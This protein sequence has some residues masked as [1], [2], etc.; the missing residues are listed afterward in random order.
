MLPSPWDVWT[1][2]GLARFRGKPVECKSEHIGVKHLDAGMDRLLAGRSL[3][4][5]W[6]NRADTMES[7]QLDQSTQHEQARS[8]AEDIDMV[9]GISDLQTAQ[10]GLDAAMRTYSQIQGLSLFKYLGG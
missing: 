4:G 6:L 8:L 5:A 9:R 3:A 10:S 1:L 2:L 7:I